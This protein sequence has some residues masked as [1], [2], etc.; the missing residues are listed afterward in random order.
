MNTIITKYKLHITTSDLDI[1]M[2][3]D[4]LGKVEDRNE[5]YDDKTSFL[6]DPIKIDKLMELLQT[7]KDH[8]ANYASI[9]YSEGHRGYDI[10]GLKVSIASQKEIDEHNEKQRQLEIARIKSHLK[11]LNDRI[12]K[13]EAELK[14]LTGL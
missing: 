12:I 1:D 7:L 8:G 3:D 5:I 14:K 11:I 2:I 13:S 10:Y 4:I 9:N 6:N